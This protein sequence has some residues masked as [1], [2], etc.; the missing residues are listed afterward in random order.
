MVEFQI[1]GHCSGTLE[2]NYTQKVIQR[3][4]N[5]VASYTEKTEERKT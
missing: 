4:E 5:V 1:Q 2:I 3:R